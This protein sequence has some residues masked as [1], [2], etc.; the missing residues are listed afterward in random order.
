MSIEN[1][2][3]RSL[4][5]KRYFQRLIITIFFLPL[6][7]FVHGQ[8]L[9]LESPERKQLIAMGYEIDKED[10]DDVWTIAR[11]GSSTIAFTKSKERLAIMRTF[12]RKSKLTKDEEV[13]LYKE[14][15]RVNVDLSY[16]VIVHEDS[17]SFLLYDHGD[18]NP[19]TFGK[20]VRMSEMVNSIFDAYPRLFSLIKGSE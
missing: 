2:M 8:T 11:L 4:N 14:I 19:K 1:I 3:L 9:S 5:S 17:I 7:F 13:N 10:K 15:N 20:I 18:Y 12:K 16:Q 6:P